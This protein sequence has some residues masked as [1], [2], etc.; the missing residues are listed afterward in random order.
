MLLAPLAELVLFLSSSFTFFCKCGSGTQLEHS[1]ADVQVMIQ[2]LKLLHI[3][4][5][6][7]TVSE[8]SYIKRFQLFF[9]TFITDNRGRP[10]TMHNNSF[11]IMSYTINS[12]N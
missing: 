9:T 12:N 10:I 5:I 2:C 6:N 7:F 8:L 4:V 11:V 3:F 1:V